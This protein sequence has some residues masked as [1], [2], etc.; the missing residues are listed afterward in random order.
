MVSQSWEN[1]AWLTRSISFSQQTIDP[2]L[3][4]WVGAG[5]GGSGG[6]LIVQSAARGT[7]RGRIVHHR[8]R[9]PVSFCTRIQSRDWLSWNLADNIFVWQLSTVPSISYLFAFKRRRFDWSCTIA[10]WVK[11]PLHLFAFGC[12]WLRDCATPRRHV[13]LRDWIC[14]IKK[15]EKPN[16]KQERENPWF[17][18]REYDELQ[19]EE[20]EEEAGSHRLFEIQK[21]FSNG[22]SYPHK[23]L[24]SNITTTT[25]TTTT[26]EWKYS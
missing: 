11:M 1:H 3:C 24:I 17:Q 19:E 26:W 6:W 15:L 10:W 13:Q 12:C 18:F 7:T 20:E 14:L 21:I 25:T 9:F 16:H 5:D 4:G 23:K 2:V 8:Q 22:F